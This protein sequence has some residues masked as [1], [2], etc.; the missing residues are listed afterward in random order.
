MKRAKPLQIA[1][2]PALWEAAVTPMRLGLVIILQAHGYIVML[3]SIVVE[4][5]VI[6]LEAKSLV[7]VAVVGLLVRV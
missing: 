1:V 7:R 4:T 5:I 6:A 3:A 2:A